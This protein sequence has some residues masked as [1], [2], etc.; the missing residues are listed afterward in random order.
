MNQLLTRTS[1]PTVSRQ[2]SINLTVTP[3]QAASGD[4]TFILRAAPNITWWKGLEIHRP[5]MAA[6]KV[7]THN[8]DRGPQSISIAASALT[9]ATLTLA[10]GKW[11]GIHTPM[12]DMQNLGQFRGQ[13]LDF[14]WIIDDDSDPVGGFFKDIGDALVTIGNAIGSAIVAIFIWLGNFFATIFEWIGNAFANFFN[15]FGDLFAGIPGIGPIIRGFFR[16]IG[17]ILNS[18]FDFYATV[19]RVAFELV[20]NVIGGV[21][22]V[23]FGAVAFLL[24]S[25]NAIPL[26][27]QGL[28]TIWHGVVGAVIAVVAKY[29]ALLQAV[30]FMQLGERGLTQAEEDLLRKVYRGS[31]DYRAIRIVEGFAGFFSTNPRPFTLVNK[32]YM[33]D[34]TPP[35]Q[36]PDALVH[37]CCHIWQNQ[38]FGTRYIS[39]AIWSG[40]TS[41]NGYD[42]ENELRIGRSRWIDFNKESQAQFFD[43]IF[44]QGTSPI[45]RPGLN[46]G[47]FFTSD[48]VADP[49]EFISFRGADHTEFARETVF[50]VRN[51]IF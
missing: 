15:W 5:G 38:H 48:P 16:W 8:D 22:M 45:T 23:V 7:F 36:H 20:G 29:L 10:K 25:S 42:W 34:F 46:P 14:T 21:V 44:N 51:N 6:L 37:E 2:D 31:L 28:A 18:F 13:T 33:K 47:S 19:I 39:E 35:I 41:S 12:Y 40:G 49:L 30:F 26:I 50:R 32:I 43:D 11:F 4:V 3:N 24:A 27:G 17:S 9:G 1:F